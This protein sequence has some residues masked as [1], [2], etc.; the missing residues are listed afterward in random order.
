MNDVLILHCMNTCLQLSR[1][2]SLQRSIGSAL[3]GPIPETR[4]EDA[5]TDLL[6]AERVYRGRG[7]VCKNTWLTIAWC[8][9]LKEEPARARAYAEE[10]AA[11]PVRNVFDRL[12][13]RKL[14]ALLTQLQ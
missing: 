14:S 7:R 8:L 12:N 5:L 1:L 6:R 4:V 3:L 11:Q 9:Q 10:A 2:S 13:Q